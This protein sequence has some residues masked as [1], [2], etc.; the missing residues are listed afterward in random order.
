MSFADNVNSFNKNLKYTGALP[1]NINVMN[2]YKENPDVLTA[3]CEFFNKFFSDNNKRNIILGI[4]PGR[5]GAGVTGIAFTDTIRLERF[6]GIKLKD[7]K[8][9]ET[10]SEFIYKMIEAYGGV[11]K[12]YSRYFISAVCPLGFTKKSKHEKQ[13]NYNYYDDKKLKDAAYDFIVSTLKKQL[14][15]G[16]NTKVC[17]CLGSGKN[18]KFLTGLN[19]NENL[20]EEIVPLDHPRYIMQYRRKHLGKYI[21]K[22]LELLK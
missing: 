14:S 1:D 6:C 2:P 19:A 10:S 16:I 7:V 4:N 12:F 20:F 18:Y 21:D 13:V 22:Y 9:F 8:S 3:A 17:F 11:K 15:F 5:H